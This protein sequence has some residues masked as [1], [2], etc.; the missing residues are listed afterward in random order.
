M[1]EKTK[2]IRS[3]ETKYRKR[4]NEGSGEDDVSLSYESQKYKILFRRFA[5][6]FFFILFRN[7]SEKSL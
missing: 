7:G 3:Q 1:Q 6:S 5:P 2:K 4:Y